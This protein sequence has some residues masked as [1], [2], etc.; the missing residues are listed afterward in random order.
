MNGLVLFTE[1]FRA[2][3]IPEF[4]IAVTAITS[5]FLSSFLSCLIRPAVPIDRGKPIITKFAEFD[6][7]L[8][9]LSEG[10]LSGEFNDLRILISR[11]CEKSTAGANK[12]IQNIDFIIF[13]VVRSRKTEELR[14][15]DFR[16]PTSTYFNLLLILI[17]FNTLSTSSILSTMIE[18]GRI[19][20]YRFTVLKSSFIF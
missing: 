19:K 14:T 12:N 15:S 11:F 10:R 6:M 18:T 9:K 5:A 16:L 20:P 8:K 7:N 1:Y 2:E 3:V 13:R 17:I 4:K